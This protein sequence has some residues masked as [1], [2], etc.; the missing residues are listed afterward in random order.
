[1]HFT[2]QNKSVRI[3]NRFI[4]FEK[5]EIGRRTLEQL[6]KESGYSEKTIR[7]YFGSC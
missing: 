1:M 5:R 3:L 6:V 2:S 7:R 4:W